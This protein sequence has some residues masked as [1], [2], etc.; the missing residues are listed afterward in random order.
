MIYYIFVG[1]LT[2]YQ[3]TLCK[4]V[5]RGSAAER[6]ANS[7]MPFQNLRRSGL[8]SAEDSNYSFADGIYKSDCYFAP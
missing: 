6:G 2:I 4:P 1:V 5:N 8:E 7:V 3:K